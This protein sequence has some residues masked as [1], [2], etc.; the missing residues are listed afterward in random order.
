[1][2]R[3]KVTKTCKHYVGGKFVRSESGRVL[4]MHDKDDAVLAEVSHAS[5]KDLRDAVEAARTAQREWA[6]K[7]AYLRGQ[8][9]YRV[10]EML[11]AR[12]N[13][14]IESR[15]IIK[16]HDANIEPTTKRA[17]K[18]EIATTIDRVVA[19]AGW[20]DKFQQV[21]GCAN[22]VAGPY[23][24]FSLPEPTGVVVA[25]ASEASG[26]L[27]LLS[28]V[29]PPL[30]AGNSVVAIAD[31]S[32]SIAATIF[33]ECCQTGDVPG[34]VVNVLA[35]NTAELYEHVASHR[36]VNA[37]HAIVATAEDAAKLKAGSAENLKR[38][39]VRVVH[40]IDLYDDH[41]F[42]SPWTIEPFIE[43]KTIWHP[44]AV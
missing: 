43:I 12:Q 11:E 5:R 32:T 7:T 28:V 31:H 41:Q 10:A 9:L 39:C 21:L 24:N 20:T 1:M 23:Y 35:G 6:A 38:V 33:A 18:K 15:T 14:L 22:A 17:A 8:I 27:G 34:G 25:T 44:S 19:F 16:P 2:S 36:A 26:L 30:C 3:L 37:V 4:T 29:L 13:E 42:E 40:D